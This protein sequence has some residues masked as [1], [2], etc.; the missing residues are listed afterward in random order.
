[1]ITTRIVP[2]KRT[3]ANHQQKKKNSDKK[4]NGQMSG[5]KN[6][7]NK[8]GNIVQEAVATAYGSRVRNTEPKYLHARPGCA[9]I[10]KSEYIKE[11]SIV[12]NVNDYNLALTTP[13]NPGLASVF[14]WLS[15]IANNYESYRFK[16]LEF[17]LYSEAP[18]NSAGY[19]A[20]AVD[21]DPADA[22][23][24]NK[25]QFM[26]YEESVRANIWQNIEHVSTIKNL[27]KRKSYFTWDGV[28][29][30][31]DPGLA[32]VGTLNVAYGGTGNTQPTFAAELWVSYVV[33]LITP[34]LRTLVNPSTQFRQVTTPTVAKELQ[35]V[36]D[37]A[38]SIISLGTG[39]FSF[40]ESL[41]SGLTSAIT[42]TCNQAGPY[43]AIF[44]EVCSA[45]NATSEKVSSIPNDISISRTRFDK[46]GHSSTVSWG[47]NE[48]A[49]SNFVALA[50]D[51][52]LFTASGLVNPSNTDPDRMF[53][54]PGDLLTCT[55]T[56]AAP[57]AGSFMNPASQ[58]LVSLL[59]TAQNPSA[60]I[61][62]AEVGLVERKPSRKRVFLETCSSN[63]PS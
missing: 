15:S 63:Q 11:I 45:Q 10:Q 33:E 20:L 54:L 52:Q 25:V 16:R 37:P 35:K 42:A 40:V 8:T 6:N 3:G 22:P 44:S 9:L 47:R 56:L 27:R 51:V 48:S 57:Y 13:I 50:P 41:N 59:L 61:S 24:S 2:A 36:W 21:Y 62:G 12:P 49:G 14:P 7:Q 29:K 5:Q 39:A 38:F 55:N 60:V 19:I 1:V 17:H 26:D 30:L 34:Q 31:D 46:D 58:L 23:P 18:T 4:K 43:S 28:A 53:F 32:Q